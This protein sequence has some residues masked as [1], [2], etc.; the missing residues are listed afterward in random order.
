MFMKHDLL[1]KINHGGKKCGHVTID[2][3]KKKDKG[4][5]II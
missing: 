1:K 4:I 2:T 5:K 3:L